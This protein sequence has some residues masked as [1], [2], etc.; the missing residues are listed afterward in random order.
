MIRAV[1]SIGANMD[2]ARE[3]LTGVQAFFADELVAASKI[4]ATPPWGGVEQGD[5]LN[6][7]LIVDT[8]RTPMELLEAGWK[9]EN[10]AGRVREIHWGPR[11]L[12]VDI[13]QVI[14]KDTGEEIISDDSTLTLP[15]PW[16]TERAFVLVPWLDADP[17]AEL[18]GVRVAELV[19]K[20]APEDVNAVRLADSAD[21]EEA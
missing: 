19:D 13:V 5:F 11:A 1:L 17:D 6:A 4:Y 8:S 20:L 16:A 12:D 10:D 9:L 15:H 21:G 14:D 3:N 18:E 2:R 7:V